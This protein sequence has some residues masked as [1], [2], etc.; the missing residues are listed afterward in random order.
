VLTLSERRDVRRALRELGVERLALQI[1]DAS[2]PGNGDE[3]VGRGA[4]ASDGAREFIG[5]VAQLGF[6][7]LQLGPQGATSPGNP[8]PYDAALFSRN[9]CSIALAPLRRSGLLP[10]RRMA[11]LVASS[12]GGRGRA[13]HRAASHAIGLALGEAWERFRAGRARR[14]AWA[15]ALDRRLAAFRR[16]EAHWLLRDGLYAALVAEHGSGWRHWREQGRPHPDQRLFCPAPGGEAAQRRRLAGL[17]RRHAAELERLAFVQL[18]AHEQHVR[19]REDCA[20]RG[21]RIYAD[22]QIGFSVGDAWAARGL[23]L[24]GYRM[25]APPSRTNPEGQPWGFP[26]LDPA[27]YHEPDGRPGPVLRYV[28]RRLARVWR[29]YDGLR[30]DHPHGWVCPWVY[31]SDDPDA[32]HAVRSGARLFSSPHRADHPRLRRFSLIREDQLEPGQPE[33]ADGQVRALEPEQVERFA[34]LFDRLACG[35][36]RDVSCEVLSTLPRPLAAVLSRHRLGRFRV[37][38]KADPERPGDVYRAESARPEDWIMLGNHDTPPI[39]AVVEAWRRSGRAAAHAR[40][41]AARLEPVAA[42][43]EAIAARLERR[44]GALVHALFADLL[45]S[46]ARHALV[47]FPD[48][49]GLKQTYN[50]PG[51]VAESNWSLRVPPDYAAVWRRRL[52][53][54]RALDVPG[55]LA[56]ALRARGSNP[57]LAARLERAAR[58]LREA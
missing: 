45:A 18:L 12:P 30:I 21:L 31:R 28:A 23:F 3:D 47:F 43:R 37:L 16:R 56:L 33:H 58:R 36:E 42:R 15:S 32:F 11:E 14:A 39:W 8:S 57:D 40:D 20:R 38:Q 35:R 2:F 17:R 27:L 41:L 9:P 50:T 55:A 51:T 19:F 13:H 53:R 25:G 26:V 52:R 7:S 46:R 24:A 10:P 34:V 44:P 22:L 49:L 29:E 1:H 54:D 5:F 6:D 4:P 48:L